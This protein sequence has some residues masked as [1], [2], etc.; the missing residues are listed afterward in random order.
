MLTYFNID[1]PVQLREKD[2][3]LTA[4]V[5]EESQREFKKIFGNDNEFYVAIYPSELQEIK[6]LPYFQKAGIK[7]FN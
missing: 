5:I 3:M 1:F 7:Y 6:I 2:Y 4:R